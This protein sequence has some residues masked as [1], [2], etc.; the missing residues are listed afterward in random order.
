MINKIAIVT[1]HNGTNSDLNKTILSVNNQ[2]TKPNLHLIISK[3]KISINNRFSFRK[4]IIGKDKSIY[5]AM[6]I[7]LENTKN[8]FLLF[9]NSGDYLFSI[10]SI[11]N[12]KKNIQSK[13]VCLNF[14]TLL[15]YKKYFYKIKKKIFYKENFFSHPSFILFNK[16]KTIKYDERY[17][18]LSD[19]IW[20]KNNSRNLKVKKKYEILTVHN[21]GGIS[22]LPNYVS[23]VDNFKYSIY[24]GSKE[25][26]KFLI[27]LLINNPKKYYEYIYKNKYLKI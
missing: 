22:S 27:Y 26:I 1:I 25:F 24:Q 2:I 10:N 4:Y 9:L 8:Y 11:K 19:G 14:I 20:M 5:N 23:I 16:K 12:L 6:N 21:L 17:K 3:K 13:N 15:K 7:G 18:I